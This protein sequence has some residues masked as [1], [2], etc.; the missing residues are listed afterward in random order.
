MANPGGFEAIKASSGPKPGDLQMM[1]QQIE[2]MISQAEEQTG[3]SG[4]SNPKKQQVVALLSEMLP[5]LN[6]VINKNN[7]GQKV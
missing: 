7:S 5:L 1:A 2:K 4:K 3:E 6:T